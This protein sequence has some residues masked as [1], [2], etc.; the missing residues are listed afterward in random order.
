[1]RI[2]HSM[3]KGGHNLQSIYGRVDLMDGLLAY[4]RI[5]F[6]SRK[7]C[8]FIF[9]YFMDIMIVNVWLLYHKSCKDNNINKK[10]HTI[11]LISRLKQLQFCV[12]KEKLTKNEE[13]LLQTKLTKNMKRKTQGAKNIIS[14]YFTG[15]DQSGHWLLL[16][17]GER[18][19]CKR[20][21]FN[22]RL[23]SHNN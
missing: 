21:R 8:H 2:M 11:S 18:K 5:L 23:R 14:E 13:G 16:K 1:M 3:P 17:G 22:K 4:Y 10:S 7:L 15:K 20:L 12:S 6:R 9:F 19:Y